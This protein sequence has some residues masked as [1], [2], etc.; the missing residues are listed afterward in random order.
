MIIQ[1][2]S[3]L[4]KIAKGEKEFSDSPY[5]DEVKNDRNIFPEIGNEKGRGL[6]DLDGEK[7]S[8]REE[9][10]EAEDGQLAI[11]V[12]QDNDYVIIKSIVGGVRP[13][14]LDVSVTSDMVTIKGSREKSE[15][16]A[17]DNY[18]YQECFW[19]S[20]SRSVILPCDIKTDQVEA[21]MKNGIL[22]IRLPKV[23]KN[24]ATRIEVRGE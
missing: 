9:I 10:Q 17:E 18:Y 13:E 1:S 7:W 19:G 14:D 2:K 12:Y 22:T 8:G 6:G 4:D 11:D 23:E 24:S 20:F 21:L 3:F 16:I 5:G 15:E